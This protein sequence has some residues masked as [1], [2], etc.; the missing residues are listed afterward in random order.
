M[1]SKVRALLAK[2]EG[3][4]NPHEAEAFFAKASELMAKHRIDEAR[5][6]ERM[7]TKESMDRVRYP[8]HTHS[9]QRASLALLNA[10]AKHYGVILLIGATGNT[11]N[12]TLFGHAS[13]VEATVMMFRSLVIQRDRACFN[14]RI[15][16]GENTTRFRNSFCYGFAGSVHERLTE[17]RERQKEAAVTASDST[18]LAVLD[19]ESIVRRALGQT[20]TASLGGGASS[21]NGLAGGADAGSRADLGVTRGIGSTGPRALHG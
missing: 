12:P 18:A 2:A 17:L 4:N 7:G 15:P 16:Y 1:I 20:R 14:T 19:R 8:L 11:K 10:V 5:V 9:Y 21:R 3:T 6:R 13:D